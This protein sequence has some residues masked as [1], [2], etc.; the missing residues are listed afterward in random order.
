MFRLFILIALVGA[1]F[2]VPAAEASEGCVAAACHPDY[3]SATY[4]H[5]PVGADCTACHE[6]TT[7]SHPGDEDGFRL[8][9]TGAELCYRCHPSMITESLYHEPVKLGRCTYCHDVHGSENKYQLVKPVNKLCVKCHTSKRQLEGMANLHPVL[10]QE[11]CTAC[12][13][14]H[15]AKYKELLPVPG[16]DFCGECHFAIR[17]IAQDAKVKHGAL[18]GG[19]VVCH[20]PHGN[21][22]PRMFTAPEE[23]FCVSCHADIGEQIAVAKSQHQPVAEGVCWGCHD[24]HGSDYYRILKAS[25]PEPFYTSYNEEE[26]QLCFMC[27]D[28]RAFRYERTSELTNFRN[29]DRNLHFLH[30]NKAAKGRVC[31]T[32]H[33]V[34]G[35]DQKK[36]VKSKIPGFGRWEIPIYIEESEVGT[37]CTVGCHK[38]KTYH[39]SQPYPND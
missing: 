1:W 34:H 5:G 29:G 36:L 11:G 25:Y 33:G 2:C 17:R 10:P 7:D 23:V 38:P 26:F 19:C 32:C 37:T 13:A 39:P 24:P 27:H 8:V 14:P 4:V 16:I 20:D 18:D 3:V 28:S 15:S 31:K 30:V 6:P 9:A 21:G 22:N 35:A 12:H